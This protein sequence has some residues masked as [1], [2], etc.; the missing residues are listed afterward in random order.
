MSS[1]SL[2]ALTTTRV[3]WSR[4]NSHRCPVPP[5]FPQIKITAFRH[6]ET[7]IFSR[8]WID[9][10]V[11]VPLRT[12]TLFFLQF[13]PSPALCVS[14]IPTDPWL[15]VIRSP[16]PAAPQRSRI[17]PWDQLILATVLKNVVTGFHRTSF[18]TIR[19]HQINRYSLW[20]PNRDL[21]YGSY[22]STN[23]WFP[24]VPLHFIFL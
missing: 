3:V 12:N 15:L 7:N 5:L 19:L 14:F 8:G 23:L 24:A 17:A 16:S 18:F 2:S 13:Q 9:D 1:V 6:I 21:F 22:V 10:F 4:K 11:K 20:P